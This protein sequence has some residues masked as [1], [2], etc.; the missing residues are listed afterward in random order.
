MTR[1]KL[2]LTEMKRNVFSY[3]LVFLSV[4]FTVIILIT[5]F[6]F[7][8]SVINTR[9]EQL[10]E[11]TM[12]TQ[13]LISPSDE[14]GDSVFETKYIEAK[15]N[16]DDYIYAYIKRYSFYAETN[17]DTDMVYFYSMDLEKLKNI[18]DL[19][20]EE[21]SIEFEEKNGIVISRKFAADNNLGL[22][23]VFEVA[24][25]EKQEKVIVKAIVAD[26]GFFADAE[27]I[28]LSKLE[29]ADEIFN[30]DG[31][32]NRIDITINNIAEI[33]QA[34]THLQG[35]LELDGLI[36]EAK[37]QS[38]FYDSYISSI[39]LALSLFVG[40]LFF[41]SVY[42]IFSV[43]KACIYKN[44]REMFVLRSIGFTIGN[45]KKLILIQMLLINIFAS[46]LGTLLSKPFIKLL[47]VVLLDQKGTATIEFIPT[48]ISIIV[49]NTASL[50]SVYI[51]INKVVKMNIIAILKNGCNQLVKKGHKELF[52]G[53]L[54]FLCAIFSYFI[55]PDRSYMG[56]YLATIVF[57]ILG[58]IVMQR[59]VIEVYSRFIKKIMG[60]VSG[61]IELF[62]KQIPFH[63]R[64]YVQSTTLITLVIM[65]TTITMSI[66]MIIQN[67]MSSVYK[68]SDIYIECYDEKSEA[69]ETII[70]DMDDVIIDSQ[71]ER[72]N[73][74]IGDVETIIASVDEQ[75]YCFM[76]Y[77]RPVK[78]MREKI[79][80]K[81]GSEDTI[82]ISSTLLKHIKKSTDDFISINGIKL[83]IVGEV[84]TFENMGSICWCSQDTFNKLFDSPEYRLYLLSVNGS[85]ENA[86]STLKNEFDNYQLSFSIQSVEEMCRENNANNQLIV[87][88]IYCLCVV[89]LLISAI[90]MTGTL[91]INLQSRK[92]DFLVYTTVGISRRKIYY[93]EILEAV[94]IG[95]YSGIMGI[96]SAF[97]I[98]PPVLKMLSFYV[99]NVELK[100]EVSSV[101]IMIII[102][103]V[104]T[105][106]S[107]TL[108]IH[109]YVMKDNLI[110]CLKCE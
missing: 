26:K 72:K 39:Q 10:R 11:S 68:G 49:V 46:L 100:F 55:L 83:K 7:S 56:S 48:L 93:T 36:L 15:L 103:C 13:L 109:K 42:I 23:S 59:Y 17:R 63:C 96:L 44:M 58:I 37:Y 98:L 31:K 41:V 4:F 69:I 5:N 105:V 21:G 77:E 52:W 65:I 32:V 61:C 45:Y 24:C 108:T 33:D 110:Q 18:Y 87:N 78:E 80:H 88:M 81:L 40:F 86:L 66:S 30:L 16:D 64:S 25:R 8:S 89:S 22:N 2:V 106:L 85:I 53:L 76:D 75:T 47:M 34:L 92:K 29:W 71:Q 1:I 70:S 73:V 79:F 60:K 94:S 91:I 84:S 95:I 27:Y 9:V 12:N 35:N 28:I 67:S 19:D 20:V 104:I 62:A 43:F 99:G 6:S 97:L 102:S 101:F 3:M 50:C 38:S 57:M 14:S 51:T 90:S 107:F 82:V 54:M 74:S